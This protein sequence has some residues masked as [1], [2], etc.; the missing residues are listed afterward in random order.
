MST[1]RECGEDI[2][3]VH[4]DDDPERF[5]PPLEYVGQAFIITD[6]N[7]AVRVTT[8]K[9]HH[10]DP[11]KILAW[12]EYKARIAEIGEDPTPDSGRRDWEIARDKQREE[13]WNEAVKTKCP[14][15]DAKKG[16]KCHNLIERKKTG[17]I[18]YTRNPHVERNP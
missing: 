15:C 7:T 6:D 16:E 10:C 4:R 17:E 11:D 1:H 3:W 14:R 8:Y 12:R 18:V 9:T 2:R 5:A 13:V